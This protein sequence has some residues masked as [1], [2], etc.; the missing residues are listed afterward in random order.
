MYRFSARLL[1]HAHVFQHLS[2]RLPYLRLWPQAQR[3]ILRNANLNC[4]NPQMLASC[5]MTLNT[6]SRMAEWACLC[7]AMINVLAIAMFAWNLN[8]W[9]MIWL[10]I[11]QDSD[12]A[13]LG[14]ARALTSR[15]VTSRR[16]SLA[17]LLL[18]ALFSSKGRCDSAHE[19]IEAGLCQCDTNA[20][21][22]PY[23]LFNNILYRD[24]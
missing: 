18:T 24:T 1:P 7:L 20:K 15:N 23:H 5:G 16:D 19:E 9:T 11:G 10:G 8:N 4:R 2:L 17:R 12:V 14:F 13:P 21:M 22:K 6:H 3:S